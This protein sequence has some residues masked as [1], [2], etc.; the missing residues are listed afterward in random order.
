MQVNLL[1]HPQ[2]FASLDEALDPQANVAYAAV[3][4]RRLRADLSSWP[5][6]AD[7]YH[8]MSPPLANAYVARVAAHWSPA[9][10][11]VMPG[12]VT[13]PVVVLPKIDPF[14]VMTPALQARVR[15][16]LSDRLA[17]LA[18]SRLPAPVTPAAPPSHMVREASLAAGPWH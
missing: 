9:R 1:F 16:A 4:L 8:S 13:A 7:A 12:T 11:F 17:L 2:A 3:F 5:M 18:R 6:A 14:D 15:D 10:G